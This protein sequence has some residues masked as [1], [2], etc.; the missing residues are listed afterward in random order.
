MLASYILLTLDT[1]LAKS[2]TCQSCMLT[3]TTMLSVVHGIKYHKICF[4]Y[5]HITLPVRECSLAFRKRAHEL[6][7]FKL[8]L[9]SY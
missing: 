3:I 8:S 6:L 4:E 2:Q 7:A 5:N 9:L 1:D